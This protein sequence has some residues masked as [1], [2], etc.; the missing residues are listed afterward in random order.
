MKN[1]I[2]VFIMFIVPYFGY[3]QCVA[4]SP[5]PDTDP[6]YQQ[7]IAA[8][9]W[10]CNNDW[11]GICQTAYD[12]CVTPVPCVVVPPAPIDILDDCYL[13]VIA[14]DS[15]CCTNSWDGLCQAAYDACVPLPPPTPFPCTNPLL[16]EIEG[17]ND[18]TIIDPWVIPN[19][20]YGGETPQ[21][22]GPRTGTH[23]LYLNFKNDFIGTAYSRTINVCPAEN[24]EISCWMHD[25]WDGMYDVTLEV[26]D[27]ATLLNTQTLNSNG[28]YF[29][30]SSTELTAITGGLTWNLI[31]N[32]STIGNNDFALDDFAVTICDCSSILPVKLQTYTAY[33]LDNSNIITWQ[34][35]SESNNDYFTLE[36]S[37]DGTT[38]R[39]LG[40]INGAGTS[41]TPLTYNFNH[42]KFSDSFN[43]YRLS[44]TDLDGQIEN[45]KV[46]SIDN[47]INNKIL[48]KTINYLG[49]ETNSNEKGLYIEIYSDGTRKKVYKP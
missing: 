5:Y 7:V 14:A 15:W 49:Q 33:N 28:A 25:T 2:I 12:V 31:N 37:L 35:A 4:V 40:T 48:I 13:Q 32:S 44:Q 18:N 23:H 39:T 34:T 38:W 46:I 36:H 8:D 16:T 21:S 19:T 3:S 30:Y 26:W 47:R 22:W 43:Y 1:K 6:C 10:C 20:T 11:D 27:G 41:N 9:A 29:N 42:D 24:F 17:W 45:F